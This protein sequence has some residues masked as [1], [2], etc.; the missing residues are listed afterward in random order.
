MYY[1]RPKYIRE[2]LVKRKGECRACGECCRNLL[3]FKIKCPFLLEN[4]LCSIHKL[5]KYLPITRQLCYFFPA[6]KELKD[7]REEYKNKKCGYYWEE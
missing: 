5:K 4:N 1:F 2:S 3:N 7:Y 6:V